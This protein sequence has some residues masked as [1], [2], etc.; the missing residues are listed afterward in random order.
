MEMNGDPHGT[1][2]QGIRASD[3]ERERTAA[4]LKEHV[5]DGRLTTDEYSERLDMTY[6][7]RTRE[8]LQKLLDD[9]PPLTAPEAPPQP[10][11]PWWRGI[12]PVAAVLALIGTLWL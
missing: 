1:T 8:E 6:T 11:G 5:L 7:A 9:L 3:A 12:H 2:H 4:L 10:A